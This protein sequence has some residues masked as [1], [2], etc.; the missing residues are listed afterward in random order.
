[1]GPL[2]EPMPLGPHIPSYAPARG[3]EAGEDH[4]AVAY[5]VELA[6]VKY[7]AI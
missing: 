6:A 4:P 5:T 1:M 2:M 3:W 7:L